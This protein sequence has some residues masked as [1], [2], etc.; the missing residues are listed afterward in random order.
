MRVPTS[1]RQ[2]QLRSLYPVPLLCHLTRGRKNRSTQAEN[3]ALPPLPSLMVQGPPPR[4]WPTSVSSRYAL[5]SQLKGAQCLCASLFW[6]K[7]S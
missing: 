5:K 2:G 7:G 4:P 3:V 6:N 1:C